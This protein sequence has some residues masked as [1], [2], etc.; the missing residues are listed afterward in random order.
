MNKIILL[1]LDVSTKTIGVSI[2][3]I[4]GM[5][6]KLL[7]VTHVRPKIPTKVKGT[8]ALFMK[9]KIFSDEI[10]E[11]CKNFNINAC[12]IEEPLI[13]SNNANTAGTLL[14][15][16][17]MI[18]QLIFDKMGIIPEYISSHDARMYAF[19]ELMAIRR[20]SKKGEPYTSQKIIHSLKHNELVLFGDYAF[21]CD[22][23]VILQQ[24][25]SDLFP[26][27]KWIYKKD[28]VTLREE[29]YDAS[30]SIVCALGYMRRKL[31]SDSDPTITEW[32]EDKEKKVISY[33]TS[34]CEETNNMKIYL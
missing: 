30:D 7:E 6:I 31:Y 11:K 9:S 18:S 29:N 19:P 20:M 8:E 23:K 17:G 22:K 1:A 13:S 4:D 2:S 5:R 32:K 26:D 25:V 21:D 33:T 34:Y 12:V 16:N 10:A 27:I 28:G 15:Y 24:K 14:R 3:E